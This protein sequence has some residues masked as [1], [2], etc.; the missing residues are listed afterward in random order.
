MGDLDVVRFA[1][2]GGRSV[3]VV[4]EDALGGGRHDGWYEAEIVI[5]TGF[6]SARLPVRCTDADLADLTAFLA[7][8][9][10]AEEDGAVPD[11]SSTDWPEAG[12]SAYLRL[13]AADPFVV[14]VRDPVQSGV[15]VTVPLHLRDGW[16]AGAAHR[17]GRLRAALA[18]G[19]CSGAV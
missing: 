10:A 18:D 14:E 5:D 11:G 12:R 1:D 17:L 16:A 9:A 19:G 4:L 8:R 7:A 13:R 6:V 2:R 15:T 3:S